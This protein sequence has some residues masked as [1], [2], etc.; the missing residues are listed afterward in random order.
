[1]KVNSITKTLL[2][3]VTLV[4]SSTYCQAQDGVNF[5][6]SSTIEGMMDK[7]VSENK[8][9]ESIK[10]WRIQIITTDDRRK[11]ESAIAKF[12]TLYPNTDLK[13]NHVPPYYRVRVGAYE[14]KNQLMALLLELK[15][16]FPSVIPVVDDVKKTELVGYRY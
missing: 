4:I 14:T 3:L 12:S 10:G 9:K 1:M 16:D 6:Y 5:T 7:F 11:M 15:P 8:S 2:L 13:W